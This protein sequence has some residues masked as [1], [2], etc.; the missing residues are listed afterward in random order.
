MNSTL[1]IAAIPLKMSWADRDENLIKVE[2]IV[3]GLHKDTDI[4]VLPELFSTGF[5]QDPD[6]IRSLAE[7]SDGFTMAKMK[8]LAREH[9]VA[10]AGSFLCEVEGK[11]YNRGFFIEPDGETCFYDKRHLF[12]L[13][14]EHTLFAQGVGLPPVIRFR[15]WNI[16]M[17]V[18]YDLRFPTWCRNRQGHN[19][20][21]VM[22][23]PANWPSSRGFAWRQLLS[24]RA[25]ENQAVYVGANR[26][27]T[28][29]FGDYSDS[30]FIFNPIG[31]IASEVDDKTGAVYASFQK[32][33]VET[34]RTKLPFG[35]DSDDFILCDF[36]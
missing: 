29:D 36:K 28:D 16:S 2:S 33:E 31:M 19:Q 32:E 15:G 21:D 9:N 22:L 1:K 20:Y 4:V 26:G 14:P 8:K 5:L 27:G 25:I 34:V 12:A 7:P 30:T 3:K 23:V 17:V 10:I 6:V 18:C 11:S 13:S 24:A 35:N